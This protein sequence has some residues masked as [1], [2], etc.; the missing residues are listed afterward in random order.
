MSI[1]DFG[2]IHGA[3]KPI[4]KVFSDDFAFTIPHYQRPYSWTTEHAGELLDDLLNYMGNGS[5]PIEEINPYFLGSIVLIKGNAPDA[6][7]VDGQQ[8]LTT[9][10]I[11]LAVIRHMTSSK[12]SEGLTTFLYEK[13]N[14]VKGTP[15]RSRLTM[16]E[17]DHDFFQKYILDE[18]G[19]GKLDDVIE[20]KLPDAKR[21]IRDNAK[22]FQKNQFQNVH[23][24]VA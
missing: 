9:L 16:R 18:D 7:V 15:D 6:Q 10:A 24:N 2:D 12:F 19:L 14:V 11:L 23:V 1:A 17:R 4:E 8:R 21:N 22:H 3:E 13:E 20:M 5:E